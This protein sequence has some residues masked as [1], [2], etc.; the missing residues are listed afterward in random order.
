MSEYEAGKHSLTGENN[1][2]TKILHTKR[3][4]RLWEEKKV[5][6]LNNSFPQSTEYHLYAKLSLESSEET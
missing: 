2:S 4:F 6:E 1:A 5:V 3:L